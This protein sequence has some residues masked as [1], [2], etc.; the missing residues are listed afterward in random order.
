LNADTASVVLK[1][2]SC[3]SAKLIK[4]DFH[5]DYA[6]ATETC[7]AFIRSNFLK[8]FGSQTA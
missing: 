3:I 5:V 1:G 6:T 8:H 4:I 7:A 2:L